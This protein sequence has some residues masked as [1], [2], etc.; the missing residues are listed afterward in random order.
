MSTAARLVLASGTRRV[1]ESAVLEGRRAAETGVRAALGALGIQEDAK[2]GHLSAEQAGLRRALRAKQRQLGGHFDVLVWECAYEQWHRMLFARFLL[3]NG[4]LRHPTYGFAMSLQ[5][6]EDIA[7]E[8]GEPDGWAV[9]AS[10]AAQILP[11]IF[12]LDDP[13]FQLPLAPEHRVRLEQIVAGL[14]VEVFTADDSLGWVYQYW[15]TERKDAVNSAAGRT[16]SA[17]IGPVT[18]LFTENYMV[19]FLLENTLGAWWAGR[20]PQSPL[21]DEFDFLRFD[22]DGRPAAGTFGDWPDVIAEVT[23]MDPCCGSGHFLVEAFGMLW[24]MRAEAEGL[25]PIAAQDAVLR[26]NLFGL[27]L[28]PRCMQIAMFAVALAAWKQGGGWRALPNPNIACSGIPAK[29]PLKEW[30]ALADGNERLEKALERLHTLFRDA[31]TLG[32]LIDPKR[33]AELTESSG[34][35]PLETV[36]FGDVAPLLDKA[37]QRETDDPATAV[38]GADAAGIARAA[39]ALSRGYSLVAT[40]LPYLSANK[41][42]ER[43]AL[44]IERVIPLGK[45]DLYAAFVVRL[46][47]GLGDT[48]AVVTPQNWWALQAHEELR[49]ALLENFD[50]PFAV[51]LGANAFQAQLW[52]F[53]VALNVWSA[54]SQRT[55]ALPVL[56]LPID[57]DIPEKARRLRE[58]DISWV[59]RAGLLKNPMSAISSEELGGLDQLGAVCDV[60]VGLTPGRTARIVRQFWE[61]SDFDTW[62]LLTS[63]PDGAAV[64]SGRSKAILGPE[65][66]ERRKISSYTRAGTRLYDR[67]GVLIAKIGRLPATLYSGGAFDNN[68][69]VVA[70]HSHDDLPAVWA[71][72]RD[73]EFHDNVRLIDQ[74]LDVT[75]SA[76]Q[77]AP[78]DVERWRAVAA[79]AFPSGLPEPW[80]DDPTQW[81][82]KGNPRSATEPL[83]VAV[84]RL[85]GYRWPE[86]PESDG[87]EGYLDG[88]GIVCL[89][90][91]GGEGPAAERLTSLL[92]A[93]FADDW[94][95]GR[96]KTLL[97]KAGS[98]K[99]TLADWLRDEFFKQHCKIFYNRPFVWHVWDG[100]KDGFAALVN[101]HRLDHGNLSKLTY[102]Y[103]GQ[104]WIERQKADVETAVA[105]A[106]GRLA[107]A[108]E[109]KEKLEKLLEGESPYDIYV[110]WKSLAEQP[111]GWRPDLDDGVR[112]NVR[113]F[114]EAGV[115][116]SKFNIH[117]R[118]DRGKNPDGSGRLND[119]H[120]TL[121][122]KHA[123][124]ES[125]S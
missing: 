63:S 19:R 45:R 57:S 79:E 90:A 119:L 8:Q 72:I 2:P 53:N 117:W 7:A 5:D 17:D 75:V 51:N 50:W 114:V 99:A 74:K 38:L 16:A 88:D 84:A 67:R 80:S 120:H 107:A 83:H 55:Q 111:I 98:K 25:D 66:I 54:G 6:C 1:L 12:R 61:M 28:D 65:E 82:F 108:L 86:Q 59:T 96:L 31:D 14:P 10:V 15:Q 71:F 122:E 87:L 27:E 64:Y 35:I 33:A 41:Q 13:C 32:S 43:L 48:V 40:N 109:L 11:G 34:Q 36:S 29:A 95:P 44:H 92:A 110:R 73:R 60:S 81:L 68:T 56:A 113:P 24:R 42:N 3:E 94:N 112:L 103:L 30:T 52:Q 77:A 70:P 46:L 118:K 58:Q 49:R 78:F 121:A 115:L 18:Q 23:V 47:Q 116:R 85:V 62:E 93:A 125:S 102:T 97:E 37:A 104:D 76:V 100:R 101:Y 4:L 89:P 21:L 9:A 26:D 106:E 123:A 105:G 20:H 39:T 124:R 69:Y 91:V 22:G